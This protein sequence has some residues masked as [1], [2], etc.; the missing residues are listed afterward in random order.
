MKV[1]ELQEELQHFD[2]NSDVICYSEDESLR[3]QDRLFCLFDIEDIDVFDAER[4]RLE[5]GTQYLKLGKSAKS[6]RLVSL[7]ITTDVKYLKK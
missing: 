6:I 1:K 2:P 7:D 3:G 4:I 5:D